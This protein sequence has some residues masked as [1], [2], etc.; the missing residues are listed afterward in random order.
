VAVDPVGQ[1]LI[2][3][4]AKPGGN[5]T[6]LTYTLEFEVAG[7]NLELLKELL[8][9][10]SRVEGLVDAT[11]PGIAKYRAG[12]P[13]A[14]FAKHASSPRTTFGSQSRWRWMSRSSVLRPTT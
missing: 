1:E 5:V 10:L 14:K 4:F 6:G 11:L 12:G 13:S 8:P 3:S 2:A 7:K 9:R